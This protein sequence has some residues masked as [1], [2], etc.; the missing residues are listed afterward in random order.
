MFRMNWRSMLAGIVPLA[1]LPT[2]ASAAVG[3]GD[4]EP[5]SVNNQAGIPTISEWSL[6]I[7]GLAVLTIGTLAIRGRRAAAELVVREEGASGMQPTAACRSL[8]LAVLIGSGTA[9]AR[10]GGSEPRQ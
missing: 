6:V 3:W 8:T 5:F 4:S 1:M 10:P 9:Q 7:F 2:S